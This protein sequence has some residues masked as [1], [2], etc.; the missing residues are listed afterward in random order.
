MSKDFGI[1]GLR[2]GYAVLD[3]TKVDALLKNGYLWNISGL[4][5]YFFNVYSDPN[6]ILKYDIVR[7]KYIMNTSMFLN[8]LKN[9]S[10]IKVY[11]S[12]A[13][14]ALIEIF[15]DDIIPA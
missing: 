14:F 8:E 15:L 3:Q 4:A 9:I 13:N 7:R 11:P 5:N 1:A 12:K 10:G 6:F 2:A